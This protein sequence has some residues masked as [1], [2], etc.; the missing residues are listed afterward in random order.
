MVVKHLAGLQ[1][2]H[3]CIDIRVLNRLNVFLAL[4]MIVA[5]GNI[6]VSGAPCVRAIDTKQIILKIHHVALWDS[7]TGATHQTQLVA[8]FVAMLKLDRVEQIRKLRHVF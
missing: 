7:H 5:A 1:L 3:C 2:L 8:A 4:N 6:L